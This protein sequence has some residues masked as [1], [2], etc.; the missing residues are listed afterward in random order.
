VHIWSQ[1][2]DGAD[3]GV[4][5]GVLQDGDWRRLID[6]LKSG[7]CTPFLGAGACH[8]VLPS[9]AELCSQWAELYSYPFAD[10]GDLPRVMQYA[11][12]S[13]RDAVYVKQ[14]VCQQ[15]AAAGPPDFSDPNEPH[16]L[17][18]QFPISVFLTTNYDDFLV[19]ALKDA[20]KSPN[21]ATCSWSAG[22]RYDEDLFATDPGLTPDSANPLVYHLHGSLQDPKSMVL[23]ENDYLEFLVKMASAHEADAVHQLIPSPVL[24]ALTDNPLLFIGYGLQDWTFRVIFHGLLSTIPGTHRRRNISVQL[25]PPI[26][27][28]MDEAKTR[29]TEYLTRYLEDWHISIYWGTAEEFC[30]ELRD[31]LGSMS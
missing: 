1:G 7:E 3:I 17:L 23:T 30:R 2:D 6:Q 8:G 29:G 9:G 5:L 27:E 10:H 24:S 13:E 21:S 31:R 15:L 28:P 19:R 12:I 22:L 26:N 25:L 20:G 4:V 14:K 11:A 16:A 18:A